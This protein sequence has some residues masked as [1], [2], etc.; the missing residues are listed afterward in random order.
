[1][2]N[3]SGRRDGDFC[4][5][6]LVFMVIC[7]AAPSSIIRRFS[8]HYVF[9]LAE[10]DEPRYLRPGRKEL[11]IRGLPANKVYFMNVVD[12]DI[13]SVAAAVVPSPLSG[14]ALLWILFTSDLGVGRQLRGNQGVIGSFTATTS[15]QHGAVHAKEF[16]NQSAAQTAPTSE[17][18]ARGRPL[19]ATV[20]CEGALACPTRLSELP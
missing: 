3:G 13:V 19:A 5:D 10:F 6:E 11:L 18:N 17:D 8:V 14:E 12:L 7:L 2:H 15:W 4:D 1:M 16:S 9:G 20:P